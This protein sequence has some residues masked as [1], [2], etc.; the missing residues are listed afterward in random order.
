MNAPLDSRKIFAELLRQDFLAF[1][2]R[3]FQELEPGKDFQIAKHM[4]AIAYQ[5]QRVMTGEVK[6]LIISMPPRM[7]KSHLV[8]ISFPAYIMAHNPSIRIVSASHTA[9]LAQTFSTRTR[10]ILQSDWYKVVAPRVRL[11]RATQTEIETT[12]GGSRLG[13]GVGGALLGRGGDIIIIDDAM[14]SD[15]GVSEAERRSV[16][17]WFAGVV[18][19]RLDNPKEGAII[20][21]AQRLHVDDLTGKLLALNG[22]THLTLPAIAYE[23]Q[24][25]ALSPTKTWKRK[26][27]ELL[28]P[29]R[30]GQDELNQLKAM[31]GHRFEAQYQQRPSPPS[32]YLFKTSKFRHYDR[33]KLPLS[34]LEAIFISV[35]SAI[36]TKETADY[37]AITVWGIRG[38]CVYLRHVERG[39]WMFRQQID[40]L[41]AL[42]EHYRAAVILIENHAGGPMLYDE[43]KIQRYPVRGYSHKDD[44]QTRAEK[45]EMKVHN[46]LVHVDPAMK[47][48]GSF[49]K[50]LADFPH[51]RHDDW[52]DSTTLFLIALDF[53]WPALGELSYYQH[54]RRDRPRVSLDRYEPWS[55]EG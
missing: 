12:C 29:D 49:M 39:R 42:S 51:G 45:A 33:K 23:D 36:S 2:E 32:G 44:K 10:T 47:N 53:A 5:L 15:G 19:S 35:D 37:T 31:Q 50:E 16:W 21:V 20:V 11:S 13:I 17:D 34:Q 38:P 4:V 22:W 54:D 9:E 43:L 1:A 46:R 55:I 30:L 27:G 41:K 28:M 24:E 25:I 18:G 52:V 40:R 8:S 3:C 48:F 26:S 14:A 7:L 6:R